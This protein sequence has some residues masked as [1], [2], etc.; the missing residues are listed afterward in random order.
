MN[1][2]EK[3]IKAMNEIPTLNRQDLEFIAKLVSLNPDDISDIQ[4][5]DSRYV[6]A[7]V[8]DS[9]CGMLAAYC[10]DAENQ[11]IS[12]LLNQPDIVMDLIEKSIKDGNISFSAKNLFRNQFYN[13]WLSNSTKL[14]D[15]LT[16]QGY[17]IDKRLADDNEKDL[18]Y[19]HIFDNIDDVAKIADRTKEILMIATR[20]KGQI[21][22]GLYT[23]NPTEAM[24]K[25]SRISRYTNCCSIDIDTNADMFYESHFFYANTGIAWWK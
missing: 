21:M 17:Y 20:Y 25:Y 1:T 9:I 15:I 23:D 5:S 19:I 16:F 3:F 2:K 8:R 6:S 10:Y 7:C 13:V 18:L 24:Q 12:Y 11:E 14:Q 22:I 4:T